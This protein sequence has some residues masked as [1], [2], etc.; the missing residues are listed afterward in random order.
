MN[1]SVE[2]L[3]ECKARLSAEI[4]AD[5]VKKTRREIVSAYATQAKVPGF[6]PGKI[7]TAVIEKRFADSIEGELKD[8]LARSAYA[9][10]STKQ[11]LAILGIAQVEREQFEADGSYLLAVEVVTEP[12]VD[13]PEY[14]GIP[15]EITRLEVNEEMVSNHLESTRKKH[16]LP[17]DVERAAGPGDIVT[18]RY[19]ATL[20]GKPLADQI[21]ANAAPIAT[22]EDHWV[23]LPEEGELPQEYIPGL[24][25][26]ALGMSKGETRRFEA[27]FPEGFPVV[28]I[29]AGKTVSYEVTALQVKELQLPDL[30]D[31]FASLFGTASLEELRTHIRSRFEGQFERLRTQTIDNKIL[32][33]LTRDSTFDLPQHVVFNETQRQVNQ[34]VSRGYE[35]GMTEDDINKNQDELI[36]SAEEHAKNNV[37]AMFLL[38]QIA[39]KEGIT[40]SDDEITHHVTLMAYRQGRPVRKVAREIRDRNAYGELRHDIRITKTIAFLREN[41]VITDV[42][43]PQENT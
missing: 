15:V 18:I 5:T 8:R 24:A 36:R 10:A 19:S 26:A 9:E 22:A 25:A 28:E 35:Q 32:A 17:V 37:K 1:I 27:T 42:D 23:I 43:P 16:A 13:L 38:D 11:S 4:P 29:I 34:M 41:A 6:R 12:E 3:P 20:D 33:I 7:P 30:D 2:R 31:K 39:N 21:E 40:V 14:K